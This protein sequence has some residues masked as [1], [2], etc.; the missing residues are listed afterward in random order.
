MVKGQEK[1]SREGMKRWKGRWPRVEWREWVMGEVRE[2][3]LQVL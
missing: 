1:G 3:G 2:G